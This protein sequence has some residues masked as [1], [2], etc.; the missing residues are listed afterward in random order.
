MTA[1]TL[2]GIDRVMAAYPAGKV[3]TA[4]DPVVVSLIG[5]ERYDNAVTVLAEP[6]KAYDWRA[7]AGLFVVVLTRKGIDAGQAIR[8][9]L[10]VAY[11]LSLH[12]VDTGSFTDVL[13][14]SPKPQIIRWK[15]A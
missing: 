10:P 7:L 15:W 13:A 9:L 12:D 4:A 14:L 6:G 5:L 1:W 11:W 3:N 8:G 2:R